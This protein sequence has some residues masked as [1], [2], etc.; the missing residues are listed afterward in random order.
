MQG[1]VYLVGG[2]PGDYQLM[3]LK[4]LACIRQADVLIYDRLV[5]PYYLKEVKLTCETI[6]VGKDATHHTLPQDKINELLVTKA[7]AGKIVTRLKGG[8]PYVF[9]RGGE[10][11]EFLYDHHV[12]FEVVPGITSAIGGL[13]YGGIPITHRD[14]ASSFHVVTGHLQDDSLDQLDWRGLARLSG[15]LV[16]LMGVKNLAKISAALIREGMPKDTPVG[17]ISQAT[18]PTQQVLTSTLAAVKELAL[19]EAVKPPTLIVIGNVVLLQNKLN[20]FEQKPLYGK[21]IVV[22]RASSQN[23][24][25]IE[26]IM[27]LGGNPIEIP[28]IK[29]EKIPNNL[30]LQQEIKELNKYQ[31]LI[32][33]STNAVKIFFEALAKT[34]LDSRALAHL[35][36]ATIGSKTAQVLSEKGIKADLIP[37]DYT[38]EALVAL[39]KPFI[40]P[41]DR[42]L[43]PKADKTR[44]V[45]VETLPGNI[46]EVVIYRTIVDD[47]QKALLLQL[48]NEDR[49]DYLTFSSASAVQNFMK[50]LG[51]E[52]VAKLNETKIISIGS[53]TTQAV[54]TA[55]LKVYQ[56]AETATIDAMIEAIEKDQ[57]GDKRC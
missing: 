41:S 51:Q 19:K 15:T 44:T 1:K 18:T 53:M 55:H 56:E 46:K 5:N 8:D 3:T 54:L 16:F 37:T 25:M 38:L 30:E 24:K 34:G 6:Y 31:Y 39:I 13:C 50:I 28:T 10:E 17:L 2:G 22:T 32:L 48:L 27:D 20:F 35:K 40:K 4:G 52:Q 42:V 57:I 33:T 23:K 14:Y 36:I 7:Q 47:R 11:A 26:K 45:L 12:P 49:I 29:I 9:G 21:N 43:I